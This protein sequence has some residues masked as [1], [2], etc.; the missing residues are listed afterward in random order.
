MSDPEGNP[1]LVVDW[2][3]PPSE[4]FETIL[5]YLDI[6]SVKALRL[7]DRR[8]AEQ[9]IGQRFLGFI[10]QPILDIS[11]QN[12]RSLHALARNSALSK[13]IHSLTFLATSLDSSG[14]EKNLKS[15]DHIVREV[16]VRIFTAT[17]NSPEELSNTESNLKWLKE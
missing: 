1:S 10:Q 2:T 4:L 8:F 7:T 14:A 11:L 16:H 9:C 6:D 15:G 12:L 17:T 3:T 5:T 13:M